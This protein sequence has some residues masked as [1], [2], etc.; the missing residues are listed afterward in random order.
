MEH[1]AAGRGA[2]G[3]AGSAPGG[4]IHFADDAVKEAKQAEETVRQIGTRTFFRRS[5]Q[6]VDSLVT[7][8]QETKARRVK[9]FSAEYFE[10]ARQH[11]RSMSQYM[12]FDEPVLLTLDKEAV[13][14]EP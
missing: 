2:N 14:I 8:E 3:A 4:G 9:Q 1:F 6:W 10:L 7:K 11:G 5:G 12:V 13:L